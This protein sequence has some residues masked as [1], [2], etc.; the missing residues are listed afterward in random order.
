MRSRSWCKR[1]I[2][3]AQSLRTLARHDDLTMIAIA[4]NTS[5]GGMDPLFAERLRTSAHIQSDPSLRRHM[6]PA[7]TA[8]KD[9]QTARD[10][11]R[12]NRRHALHMR[13]LKIAVRF[14]F[15]VLVSH[16][17]HKRAQHKRQNKMKKNNKM[18]KV[19][20]IRRETR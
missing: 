16:Y 7:Q 11:L 5:G 18:K 4:S 15:S 8:Q 20:T 2:P 3:C 17:T 19:T 12:S 14:A 6:S 9:A 1:H 13:Q 10:C